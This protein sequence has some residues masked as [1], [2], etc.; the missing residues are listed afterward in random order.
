MNNFFVRPRKPYVLFNVYNIGENI[1]DDTT[2]L[3]LSKTL[4][5]NIN[6]RK[7]QIADNS[8]TAGNPI[9]TY[10]GMTSDQANDADNNLSA[11]NGVNL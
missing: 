10:K 5:D 1:I 8:D 4:Q 7:R 3:E 11:G 6:D 9:R 2:P